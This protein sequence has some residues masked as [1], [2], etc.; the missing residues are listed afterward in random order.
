[1]FDQRVD[2]LS[3]KS[4]LPF[5]WFD[6]FLGKWNESQNFPEAEPFDVFQREQQNRTSPTLYQGF[7]RRYKVHKSSGL[8]SSPR[9]VVSFSQRENYDLA[10][11]VRRSDYLFNPHLG[12]LPMSYYRRALDLLHKKR[13]NLAKVAIY[14]D[15]PE[16]RDLILNSHLSSLG[17]VKYSDNPLADW[18]EIRNAKYCIAANSTFAYT[19][20]FSKMDS[21]IFPSP[22]YLNVREDLIPAETNQIR[23]TK[24]PKFQY[25][26]GRGK[27]RFYLNRNKILK[28]KFE[29][30]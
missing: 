13:L 7:S 23:F 30:D 27:R 12:T 26:L 4:V 24:F 21:T 9:D 1:M 17:E 10:I 28:E 5:D 3:F 2:I 8:L 11:S 15:A 29:A 6:S 16:T 18:Q 25:F 14:V 20:R 19:A 22:F